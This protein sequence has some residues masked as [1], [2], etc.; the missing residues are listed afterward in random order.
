MKTKKLTTAAILTALALVLSYIERWIPLELLFPLP[1]IK[2][3]L[4]NTVTLF[5]VYMLSPLS[6][7]GI[8]IARCVL[9]SLFGGSITAFAFSMTGGILSLLIMLCASRSRFLSVYG[10]S[11]LGAAAHSTGQILIAV[12]LMRSAKVFFYLPYL[13]LISVLCGLIT[14]FIAAAVMRILSGKGSAIR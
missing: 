7:F 14:A 10:T 3:G 4:A 9:S 11:V 1:G 13:L 8:L 2:L 12:C 6:A 5:A